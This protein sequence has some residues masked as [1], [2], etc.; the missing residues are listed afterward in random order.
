MKRN[1]RINRRIIILGFIT[2]SLLLCT[3]AFCEMTFAQ[4]GE[5]A[6]S[7][8]L[9][10]YG[11]DKIDVSFSENSILVK[12]LQPLAEFKTLDEEAIR[13]AEITQIVS[14]RLSTE[15]N[16]CIHQHFDDGQI[17]ELTIEPK[18]ARRFLNGQLTTE[19][20]LDK[21]EMKPLT[22]GSPIVPGRCEPDKGK[23]CKNYEACTCYPNEVCAPENPQANEKGCVEKYAPSNAHLVGS[24][25]VCNK[26]HE[27]NSDLTECVQTPGSLSIPTAGKQQGSTT[28]GSLSAGS[29][30]SIIG[31]TLLLDSIPP[32]SQNQKT[33]FS[34]GDM[35]YVWVESR[36]LNKPHKL[37]TVWVNPSGKE[38]K[39]EKFDLRGWGT[40]ET[41]WS[42]LQTG[43]QMMQGQWQIKFLIDGRVDR[44]TYFILEP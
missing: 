33:T 10:S 41:V 28:W 42:E 22:R 9:S 25:Y 13:V 6:V 18:D 17:I 29:S 21:A 4:G 35:I 19:A 16:V 8:V 11:L 15:K 38:I 23:N 36:A 37:E 30:G 27:W 2:I 26:G 43:R 12:Y 32:T 40:K 3:G 1:R 20:F 7:Q 14:S 5:Q 34:P 31:Q 24:E 44:S 39:R